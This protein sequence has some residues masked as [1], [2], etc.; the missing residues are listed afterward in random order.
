MTTARI[1]GTLTLTLGIGLLAGC[2]G[3]RTQQ[4]P[5]AVPALKARC[6]VSQLQTVELSQPVL[7]SFV[8]EVSGLSVAE[9]WGRWTDGGIAK[10]KLACLLPSQFSLVVRGGAFGPNIG[11]PVMFMVGSQASAVTF[12]GTPSEELTT[13]SVPFQPGADADTLT[14][15]VPYPTSPP[16]DGRRLG[17]GLV[18][19][20]F[21]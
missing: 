2:K 6:E 12:K 11:Q 10:I 15:I 4:P 18:S 8:A 1:M 14:I 3:Q 5:A 13:V 21:E 16:N 19:M 17:V 7:P 20:R 9:P